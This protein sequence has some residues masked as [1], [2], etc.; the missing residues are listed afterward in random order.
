M[1]ASTLGC[2][3]CGTGGRGPSL[4]LCQHSWLLP[5]AT[6]GVGR[7][8]SLP[9]RERPAGMQLFISEANLFSGFTGSR[10]RVTTGP[11]RAAASLSS[12]SVCVG[13]TIGPVTGAERCREVKQFAQAT[14]DC[15]QDRC[16]ELGV[17]GRTSFP[18]GTQN[19]LQTRSGPH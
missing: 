11:P 6:L 7:Q 14:W 15:V 2:S 18:I 13:V 17:S 5:A 4:Q 1:M 10:G 12:W 16:D 3:L 9:G 8:A 19:Y